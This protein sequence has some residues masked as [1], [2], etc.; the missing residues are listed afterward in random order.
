[1]RSGLKRVIGGLWGGGGGEGEIGEI[2]IEKGER[3]RQ[4]GDGERGR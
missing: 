3:I 2:E 1:M 4:L